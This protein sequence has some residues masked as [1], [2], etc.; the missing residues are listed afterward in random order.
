ML[1]A[2]L[3]FEAVADLDVVVAGQLDTALEAALH[4]LHIVLHTTERFRSRGLR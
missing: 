4:F 2:N 1:L 3:R